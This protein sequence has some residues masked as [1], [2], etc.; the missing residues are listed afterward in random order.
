MRT[1]DLSPLYRTFI[2]ADRM[3]SQLDSLDVADSGGFPPYDIEVVKD[4][5][6]RIS[7]AVAGFSP[8]ELSIE[9]ENNRL[10]VSGVK[11]VSS[12]D[13]HY[14]YQGIA[15]RNFERRFQLADHVEVQS[16]DYRDGLLHIDLVREIPEAMKPRKIAIGSNNSNQS[17]LIEG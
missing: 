15:R 13:A 9:Q 16:A 6:Y 4:N 5:Q 14:L 12:S 8:G 2:G 7:L 17:D 11:A 10:R 3:A 1:I